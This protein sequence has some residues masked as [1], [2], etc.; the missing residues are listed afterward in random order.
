MPPSPMLKAIHRA[1]TALTLLVVVS[2]LAL[3]LTGV[4]SAS[5]ALLLF[6]SVEVPLL[7]V[8]IVITV[9]RFRHLSRTS[10]ETG[11]PV[12]DLLQQEEPLLRFMVLEI[13]S[14]ASLLRWIT[15]RHRVPPKAQ[16]FGYTRGSMGIPVVLVVLSVI[17]LVVVHFLVPW[18]WLQLVLLVLTVW[19]VL[20]ILGLLAARIVNPHYLADSTLVLRWGHHE[21]LR[22][23]V[24]NVSSVTRHANHVHTQPHVEGQRLTLTSFQSTNVRILL[25]QPAPAAPPVSKKQLP[26]DFHASELQLRVDSPDDLLAALSARQ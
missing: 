17:E 1:H 13:R 18:L 2:L 21:V 26:P 7:A 9:L 12:L 22:T 6:L 16:A 4:I 10:R 11:R 19:G 14:F 3:S 8:F 15:R 24:S 25:T 23:P 20:F 5:T